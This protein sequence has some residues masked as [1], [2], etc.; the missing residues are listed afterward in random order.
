MCKSNLQIQD[1][2]PTVIPEPT[3]YGKTR[4]LVDLIAAVHSIADPLRTIYY[5]YK[6]WPTVFRGSEILTF[7]VCLILDFERFWLYTRVRR[8]EWL[9][10]CMCGPSL[11]A[12]VF[13]IVFFF[14]FTIN[15]EYIQ[16]GHQFK[17]CIKCT[18]QLFL[19]NMLIHTYLCIY[20]KKYV[21]WFKSRWDNSYRCVWNLQKSY[22]NQ[23]YRKQRFNIEN[24]SLERKLPIILIIF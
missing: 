16:F 3:E 23:F 5:W 21:L 1:F 7:W 13:W 12:F 22:E 19:Y 15:I 24:Q 20:F 2:V 10:D 11:L 9:R 14:I 18:T 4:L 8:H 17:R 6:I